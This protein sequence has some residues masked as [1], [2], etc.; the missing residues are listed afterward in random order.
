MY[1]NGGNKKNHL[2]T[3]IDDD[4]DMNVKLSREVHFTLPFSFRCQQK[5]LFVS[6]LKMR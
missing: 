4:V 1:F 6:V 3:Y 5:L 2:I